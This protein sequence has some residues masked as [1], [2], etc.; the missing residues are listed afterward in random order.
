MKDNY[1]PVAQ[2]V[3]YGTTERLPVPEPERRVGFVRELI[4][5]FLNS[6]LANLG[7]AAVYTL[8]LVG[9]IL[10]PLCCIGYPI[11]TLLRYFLHFLARCDAR[12]ANLLLS[13]EDQI[14]VGG[15]M[16]TVPR[17][18]QGLR[19]STQ[20][21]SLCSGDTLIAFVYFGFFKQWIVA[22]TSC[23]VLVL[24]VLSGAFIILPIM[25][26]LSPHSCFV[27]D[28]DGNVRDD[29]CVQ[30]WS[31][32]PLCLL[33]YLLFLLAKK[34]SHRLARLSIQI[35]KRCC[36]ENFSNFVHVYAAEPSVAYQPSAP[37]Q[38]L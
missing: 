25:S 21:R 24:L 28:D 32:F 12:L 22:F 27:P 14:I 7:G 23:I 17:M 31:T 5:H 30:G 38:I 3:H 2:P 29:D 4:F 34:I 10:L 36:C 18:M 9:V 11:L 19:V 37:V 6:M 26:I 20:M 35:T 16:P 8:G 13:D 15:E 33:G 1:L